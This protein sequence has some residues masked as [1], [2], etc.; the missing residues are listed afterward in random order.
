MNRIRKII[1]RWLLNTAWRLE[2]IAD[3]VDKRPPL[4]PVRTTIDW[5]FDGR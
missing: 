1:R 4:P 5:P 2:R 3:R